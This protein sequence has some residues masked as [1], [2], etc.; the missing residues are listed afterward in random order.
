MRCVLDAKV[1]VSIDSYF[2]AFQSLCLTGSAC[3]LAIC[4]PLVCIVLITLPT[5]CL[6]MGCVTDGN[7][8]CLCFELRNRLGSKNC[9]A[10]R[11]FLMSAS[12]CIYGRFF[13][14]DPLGRWMRTSL[15]CQCDLDTFYFVVTCIFA[16]ILRCHCDRLVDLQC[17]IQLRIVKL[18]ACRKCYRTNCSLRIVYLYR[19]LRHV[20]SLLCFLYSYTSDQFQWIVRLNQFI[21]V[22]AITNQFQFWKCNLRICTNIFIWK[23]TIQI[24]RIYFYIVLSQYAIQYQITDFCFRRTIVHFISHI[25]TGNRKFCFLYRI[26]HGCTY[27][28]FAC[29]NRHGRSIIACVDRFTSY[30]CGTSTLIHTF[31]TYVHWVK[32]ILRCLCHS[33]FL[34]SSSI[35]KRI[36][37]S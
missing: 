37:C 18:P 8:R 32:R 19:C 16:S 11:T 36:W 12:F 27:R 28:I 17:R 26:F 13:I 10:D 35:S 2:D 31:I 6:Y 5:V 21:I 7:I 3:H 1:V 29:S 22:R 9:L 30:K 15:S 23:I 14:D 24:H 20:R 25:E 34:G 33:C 4:K